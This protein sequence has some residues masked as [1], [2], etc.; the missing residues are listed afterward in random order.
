MTTAA[1]RR[2]GYRSGSVRW[3]RTSVVALLMA[4]A[5]LVHHDATSPVVS[6]RAVG[7]MAGSDHTSATAIPT[8]ASTGHD[9]APRPAGTV[10]DAP[11]GDCAGTAMQHCSTADVSTAQSVPPP[12]ASTPAARSD[13]VPGGPALHGLPRTSHR[14][15][16]DLSVLSRLL[17]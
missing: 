15:P 9:T 8:A 6:A 16:P 1:P 2:A 17:I 10:M 3:V 13:A 5:V 4:L 11:G 14:A 12:A 7:S